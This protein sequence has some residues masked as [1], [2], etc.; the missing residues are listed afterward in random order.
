MRAAVVT[1]TVVTIVAAVV[2][3]VMTGSY[4]DDC[5]GRKNTTKYSD[6]T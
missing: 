6:S 4:N 1:V 5:Q 3:V 2:V